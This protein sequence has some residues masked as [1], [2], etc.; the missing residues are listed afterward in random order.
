VTAARLKGYI[1]P[2]CLQS[3][4]MPHLAPIGSNAVKR[5]NRYYECNRP[6]R[7]SGSPQAAMLSW[8]P[9]PGALAVKYGV[10]LLACAMPCTGCIAEALERQTLV[11]QETPTDI[12]YQQALDNLAI[13]AHDPAALPAY[14]SIFAGTAEITDTAQLASTTSFGP[15][16]AGGEIASP[17]YSRAVL[18]NWTL[19][20]I[21]APEKLEAIRCA[22]R[23]VIYGPEF[24]CHDCVGLLVSPEEAP[25]PGRHFGVAERLAALPAGWLRC[26]RRRDVPAKT[27]YKAHCGDT[28]VWVTPNGTGPLADFNLILQ[29]IA[30]VDINS[31]TLQFI[32]PT[33]SDFQF[34][35]MPWDRSPCDAGPYRGKVPNV[36]AEVS[37]DQCGHLMPDTPYYKWRLE[38]VGSDASLRSQ[39]SAAG[40]H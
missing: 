36:V 26:G 30:R 12:R 3:P 31:P 16:G 21:N 8:P 32:R 17:Q 27:C 10:L 34:P 29:D 38:N 18:G 39:I 35:T 33:P 11:Q 9:Y 24:A 28:W 14:S 22:C 4:Q 6:I 23:W 40:L 2:L 25:Y 19:D 15:P 37:V 1:S 13:V 5:H 7:F 20:P